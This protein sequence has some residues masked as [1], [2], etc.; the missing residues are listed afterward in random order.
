MD[1]IKLAVIFQ[2]LWA[3]Y[4]AITHWISMPPWNDLRQELFAGERNINLIILGAVAV[5]IIGF[6]FHYKPIMWFGVLFWSVS[7]IGHISFWWLPYFFGFP[8][9][10][11]EEDVPTTSWKFLPPIKNHPIPDACHMVI[12][13][14]TLLPF[15]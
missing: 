5:S 15:I 7:M 8:K 1:Y 14:L 4:F 11:I 9:V 12:G 13:I 3:I 6:Y 2:I 10:F